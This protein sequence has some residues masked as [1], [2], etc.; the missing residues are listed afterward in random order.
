MIPTL[1][2]GLALLFLLELPLFD[3]NILLDKAVL[4]FLKGHLRKHEV[5]I[6]GPFQIAIR[7]QV[8]LMCIEFGSLHEIFEARVGTLEII[9]N[10]FRVDLGKDFGHEYLC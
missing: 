1:L 5:D 10:F 6:I 9:D 2:F 3:L 4:L 7:P 8:V